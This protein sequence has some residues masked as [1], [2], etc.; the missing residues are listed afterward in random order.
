LTHSSRFI[1]NIEISDE[2]VWIC[3]WSDRIYNAENRTNMRTSVDVLCSRVVMSLAFLGACLN[4]SVNDDTF[5]GTCSTRD[6]NYRSHKSYP[7]HRATTINRWLPL[8]HRTRLYYILLSWPYGKSVVTPTSKCIITII[9]VV[10]VVLPHI[11]I[12]ANTWRTYNNNNIITRR[13]KSRPVTRTGR[14]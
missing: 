4:S 8:Y 1:K 13:S 3:R 11:I 2:Y 10:V 12:H 6:R 7:P 5:S 9:V 14:R